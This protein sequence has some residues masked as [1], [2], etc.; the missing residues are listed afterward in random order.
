[1]RTHRT[2]ERER[3]GLLSKITDMLRQD[4]PLTAHQITTRLGLE[5]RSDGLS[6]GYPVSTVL[7]L[8]KRQNWVTATGKG[9]NME[10]SIHSDMALPLPSPSSKEAPK[11]KKASLTPVATVEV[12]K[13]A[14][15]LIIKHVMENIHD[16]EQETQRAV[17]MIVPKIL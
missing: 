11:P 17:L 16:L 5:R 1:M 14:L 7:G 4:S 8:M 15:K 6:P 13:C 3:L 12:P 10:Y 2:T 9:V